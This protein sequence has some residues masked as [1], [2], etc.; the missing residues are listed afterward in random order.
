MIEGSL[1]PKRQGRNARKKLQRRLA[2]GLQVYSAAGQP[3]DKQTL[4]DQ[5]RRGLV[6]A[7]AKEL[8]LNNYRRALRESAASLSAEGAWQY[9]YRKL[10]EARRFG[11]EADLRLLVAEAAQKFLGQP[12]KTLQPK[13]I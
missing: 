13:P 3:K 6:T 9:L 12:A 4:T 7:R 1:A 2:E 5:A 8:Y 10:P 11:L